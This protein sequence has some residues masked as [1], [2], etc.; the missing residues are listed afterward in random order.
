M[1]NEKLCIRNLM[2]F[3]DVEENKLNIIPCNSYSY[4]YSYSDFNFKFINIEII[5]KFIIFYQDTVV[6]KLGQVFQRIL[7]GS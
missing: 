1:Y 2:P 6:N 4:S 7:A 3:K 5:L